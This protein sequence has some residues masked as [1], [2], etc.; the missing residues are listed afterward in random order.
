LLSIDDDPFV[1][2]SS[3]LR[4]TSAET[5]SVSPFPSALSSSLAFAHNL[6]TFA[7]LFPVFQLPGA[8]FWEVVS[9]EHGIATDGQ[10]VDPSYKL[11]DP[12]QITHATRTNPIT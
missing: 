2:H 1:D 6:S 10:Y 9:D 3:F 12:I 5:K 8:K 7:D 4:K 11:I